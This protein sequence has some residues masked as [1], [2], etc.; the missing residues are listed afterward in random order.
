MFLRR[1]YRLLKS[2]FPEF[3]DTKIIYLQNFF[4][5][6]FQNEL[7][8]ENGCL[9]TVFSKLSTIQNFH[10]KVKL[11]DTIFIFNPKNYYSFENLWKR[12]E[13]PIFSLNVIAYF[14]PILKL[15]W[16]L[17]SWSLREHRSLLW[18]QA[19]YSKVMMFKALFCNLNFLWEIVFLSKL[20]VVKLGKFIWNWSR[21]Q[22]LS[23]IYF[24]F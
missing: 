10:N 5:F 4:H 24:Y 16:H 7:N 8:I 2:N 1:Y 21:L 14:S 6:P 13:T 11:Y 23:L 17:C 12:S 22:S 15:I 9:V 19:E 18:L 20:A 3:P